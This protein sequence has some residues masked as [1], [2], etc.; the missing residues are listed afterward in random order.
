[1]EDIHGRH[2]TTPLNPSRLS[3][4]PPPSPRSDSRLPWR[5]GAPRRG[6]PHPPAT[7][8]CVTMSRRLVGFLFISHGH[9]FGQHGA[10]SSGS[11][12]SPPLH[13]RCVTASIYSSLTVPGNPEPSPSIT[14]SSASMP[15]S[16]RRCSRPLAPPW[17]GPPG[18]ART[19]APVSHPLQ[20]P[21][22]PLPVGPHPLF[23]KGF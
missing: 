9:G 18:C 14:V 5:T 8:S 2:G 22:V 23:K 10:T 1:M 21:G 15:F 3:F 6:P 17:R 11:S 13:H 7:S 20:W 12:R 4:T 19:R 16:S